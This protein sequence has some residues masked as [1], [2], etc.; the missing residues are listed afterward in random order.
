MARLAALAI[1][2]LAGFAPAA[3]A[4][5]TT[6][7]SSREPVL[8]TVSTTRTVTQ[9]QVTSISVSRSVKVQVQGPTTR[10]SSTVAA[11]GAPDDGGGLPG[12]A[13][14]LIA[15]AGVGLLAAAFAA[16]RHRKHPPDPGAPI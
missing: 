7:E 10:T 11:A 4:Q 9:Q 15:L 2:L 3:V 6:S 1:A 12:W 14:A 8:T 13:W 16:G 5:T